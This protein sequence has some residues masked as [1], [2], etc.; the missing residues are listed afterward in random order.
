MK[1]TDFNFGFN[2]D[3]PPPHAEDDDDPAMLP[4]EVD[5]DYLVDFVRSEL[6]Q[7][8]QRIRER[9]KAHGKDIQWNDERRGGSIPRSEVLEEGNENRRRNLRDVS[10]G[11]WHQL[12]RALENAGKRKR[13]KN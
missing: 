11:D 9:V 12:Q 4:R 13:R 2:V 8:N 5:V 6:K 10:N 1:Q 7:L 3:D